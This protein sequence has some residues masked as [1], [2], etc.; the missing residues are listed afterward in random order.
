MAVLLGQR[1]FPL[2]LARVRNVNERHLL[3][4]WESREQ[5]A[6]LI[7]NVQS[8]RRYAVGELLQSQAADAVGWHFP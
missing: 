1:P 5:E 3:I 8:F 6:G 4:S 2:R 7:R